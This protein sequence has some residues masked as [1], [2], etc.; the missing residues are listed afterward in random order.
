MGNLTFNNF[1]RTAR[2]GNLRRTHLWHEQILDFGKLRSRIWHCFILWQTANAAGLR[3]RPPD[4]PAILSNAQEAA[5]IALGPCEASRHVVCEMRVGRRGAQPQ[6]LD[7]T[8]DGEVVE[9][10]P[11]VPGQTERAVQ[12]IIEVAANARAANTRSFGR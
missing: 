8:A 5:I 3:V 1:K 4:E 12:H 9:T 2:T 10:L 11:I 7:R 6:V